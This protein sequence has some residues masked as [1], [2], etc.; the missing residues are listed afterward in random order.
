MLKI[1]DFSR[2]CRVPVSALRYYA[3]LGLLPPARVD[4][5]TG[6]RYY[7]VAQL[8]RL[9]RILA[10]R[11]LGLSL[12]QI[13][14]VL[15]EGLS[16][17]EIRGMLRLRRAELQERIEDERARLARVEARLRQIEQEGTMA[18]YDV[19]LKEIP[20]QL[21]AGVRS[22]IPHYAAIGGLFDE[23]YAHLGRHGAGGLA[24][25]LDHN[26]EYKERDPDMEAVVYL[27][28]PVPEG[29]R[30]RVYTLPGGHVASTVHKG[31]YEGFSQ[32]YAAL[33]AWVEAS[34]YQV[35]G[36]PRELY[37]HMGATPDEHIS[38]VQLP[39]ARRG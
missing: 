38:E 39:V 12:E 24:V 18:G 36:A 17:D 11:D 10:L 25:G 16:A 32:A 31:P 20:P 9:Q 35:V 2:L 6:Y 28:A 37:L 22:V 4:P 26:D 33:M 27:E 7:A 19:V 30:V 21:V 29:G 13:G 15:R 14:A 34:G 5:A 1:G 23:L 3:D 8:P